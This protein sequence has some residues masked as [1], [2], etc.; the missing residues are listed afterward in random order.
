MKDKSTEVFLA[1]LFLILGLATIV[2]AWVRPMPE[3]ERILTTLIGSVGLLLALGRW[4]F[5]KSPRREEDV[6]YVLV[7]TKDKA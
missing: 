1:V 6:E 4:L 3:S 7:R 5:L 2:L